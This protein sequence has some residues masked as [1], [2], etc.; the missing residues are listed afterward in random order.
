MGGV[1]FLAHDM[2]LRFVDDKV[3]I[4]SSRGQQIKSFWTRDF[5]VSVQ[6]ALDFVRNKI[7]TSHSSEDQCQVN[8][9]IISVLPQGY[10]LLRCWWL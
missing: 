8:M 7:E 1:I 3:N 5:L 6:M 2:V 4:L 9:L 10:K